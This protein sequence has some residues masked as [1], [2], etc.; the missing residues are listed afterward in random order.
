[1]SWRALRMAR[2]RSRWPRLLRDPRIS[3]ATRTPE[4][5]L[6]ASFVHTNPGPTR[7]AERS[8]P[9]IAQPPGERAVASSA[10][11][12][13]KRS[14]SVPRRTSTALATP[15]AES[16][17]RCRGAHRR[18]IGYRGFDSGGNG[19]CLQGGD[20]VRRFRQTAFS[21]VSAVR[22]R[23][24][25]NIRAASRG[26]GQRSHLAANGGLAEGA[27]RRVRGKRTGGD[28]WSYSESM[29]LVAS[30][31]CIVI[32]VKGYEG[33]SHEVQSKRYTI[34]LFP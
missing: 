25:R 19:F 15:H 22:R 2:T 8:R 32:L 11:A 30:N 1:M 18:Y 17:C 10:R 20:N 28:G 34:G 16:T 12:N 3:G 13:G 27:D 26:S 24:T 5:H 29:K 9:R 21:A 31:G 7:G 14:T 33:R 6:P 4:A 23:R